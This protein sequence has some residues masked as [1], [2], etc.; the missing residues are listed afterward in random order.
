[1]P[2]R[3][4]SCWR[5]GWRR[6]AR[7][8]ATPAANGPR[9]APPCACASPGC[10]R[11]VWPI[12]TA[13]SPCWSRR[14]ASWG[15]RPPSPSR[16]PTSTSARATRDDLIEL[17]QR[18][19]SASSDAG[20]RGG[21]HL[22]RGD[23]LRKLRREA[24]AAEAY[25]QV[26]T[27]RP[28]DREAESALRELYR[29]LGEHEPLARLLE[30]ELAR[31]ATPSEVATRLELAGLL[32]GPLARPGEALPHLRRVLQ[33]EPGQPE[34]EACALE[35]AR[36]AGTG[37][38]PARAAGRQRSRTRRRRRRARAACCCARAGSPRPARRTPSATCARRW[39]STRR[40]RRRAPI[41]S[42]CSSGSGA[43]RSCSPRSSR[44]RWPRTPTRA[45]SCSSA[46]P[47]S[48]GSA[49]PPTPR[50]RGWRGC[51]A[52][53]P[54]DA[55]LPARCAE[56]HRLAGRA[57]ARLRALGEELA[58]VDG[59][60]AAARAAARARR[61]CSS[62]ISRLPAAPWRSWRRSGVST[63]R[64]S[65][66]CASSSACTATSGR[67]RERV[68]MLEALL[69]L[70]DESERVP[71]LCE[72]AALWSGPLARAAASR[73]APAAGRR[74]DA[75]RQRPARRAAARAGRGAARRRPAPGVGS[76]RGGG[77]ARAR[78][79]GARLRGPPPRA[80]PRA[81]ARLRARAAPP[82]R[83][84]APPAIPRR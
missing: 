29:R 81:R 8:R 65:R 62:T 17:C 21:W 36:A 3:W 61:A 79:R 48:P 73:G 67:P 37:R 77:A 1:M 64:T 33:L 52:S 11:P 66:S 78:P 49:S 39:P 43:G 31:P 69:A 72:A 63:R 38:S 50:C 24:E 34:A 9:S 51:A 32:A 5:S 53:D 2:A 30:T 26:L 19:A 20:E 35:I 44:R 42:P 83:G 47:R 40:W 27:D 41:G 75:A 70:T 22:R 23:A 58:L 56:A 4:S 46:A 18:A 80:G 15:R 76:L 54:S 25:R 71:L 68:R 14:S 55:S 60:G 82:R 28:G 45:P 12:P 7:R 59:S 84:A 16:S 10:A 13:R 6:P 74:R 57:E